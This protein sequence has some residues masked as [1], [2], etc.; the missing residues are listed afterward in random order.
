MVPLTADRSVPSG[1]VSGVLQSGVS[2]QPTYL[3]QG[4]LFPGVC[5]LCFFI[6]LVLEAC[7][8]GWFPGG[9]RRVRALALAVVLGCLLNFVMG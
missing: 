5:A 6:S 3:A 8:L 7:S 2:G 9:R 4:M 1:L